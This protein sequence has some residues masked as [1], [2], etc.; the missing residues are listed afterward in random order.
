[1]RLLKQTFFTAI[2]FLL[3]LSCG[4]E[5]KEEKKKTETE[6]ITSDTKICKVYVRGVFP[7]DD[8]FEIFFS[9]MATDPFSQKNSMSARFKGN[10]EV[11]ELIFD[12]EDYYP[13][14]IRLDIG[15]NKTM[16]EIIIEEIIIK[17]NDN[18][19]KIDK[20][21]ISTYLKSNQFITLGSDNNILLMPIMIEGKEVY[22][23]F[24]VSSPLLVKELVRL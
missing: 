18:V 11:Q 20:S 7:K 9:E 1:M 6:V 24:F 17:Y 5:K 14:K 15:N 21:K 22:D 12:L 3:T 2:L 4:S 10:N 23:P 8:V 13:E 16:K 19:F